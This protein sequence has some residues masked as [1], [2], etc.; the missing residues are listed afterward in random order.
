MR[1]PN[2]PT[3]PVA[4]TASI[5]RMIKAIE[6]Q[7]AEDGLPAKA[8]APSARIVRA[9]TRALLPAFRGVSG[10]LGVVVDALDDCPAGQPDVRSAIC[11][12]HRLLD[13][14][15][16][17]LAA[18]PP[19]GPAMSDRMVASAHAFCEVQAIL[20]VCAHALP[21]GSDARRVLEAA[22]DELGEAIGR[23]EELHAPVAN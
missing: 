12:A 13:D 3:L 22:H 7:Q 14:E 21:A 15:I 4:A 16:A 9:R 20:S 23:L 18:A 5:A 2:C 17:H 19:S 1:K 8:E 10:A 11:V 6:M